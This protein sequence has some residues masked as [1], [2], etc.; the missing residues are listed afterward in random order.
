MTARI[1]MT[2]ALALAL[3]LVTTGAD[4]TDIVR[5]PYVQSV[6]ETSIRV[7]WEQDSASDAEVRFGEVGTA[8]D[9]AVLSERAADRH[10]MLLDGL[11]AD[12]TY[13]Y[14]VRDTEGPLSDEFTFHTAPDTTVA[15][16]FV[17]FGDT[18][19]DHAAH[20]G[21]VDAIYDELDVAFVVNTG[22]LV[23]DGEVANQWD[24][25]FEVEHDLIAS[26]PIYPVIG[27]HEEHDGD[28]GHY[29]NAFVLPRNSPEPEH[30]YS[31]DYSNA[32]FVVLDGH[33]HVDAWYVCAARSLFMD[34][35]FDARQV[36]WLED[37]LTTASVREDIDHIFV[38]THVGPYS[39]K[40]GRSGNA[41][42][43]LLQDIFLNTG[44]TAIISGHDHYYEHGLSGVGIHYIIS[45][46]GGAPLYD[47]SNASWDP[48]EVYENES[49]HHYVVLDVMGPRVD[50]RTQTLDSDGR[51]LEE[52][53]IGPEAECLDDVDCVIPNGACEGATRSCVDYRCVIE[54]PDPPL[55]PAPDLSP[56]ITAPEVVEDTPDA[57]DDFSSTPEV[58]PD[59]TTTED[60]TQVDG[61]TPGTGQSPG[62]VDAP[63]EGCGCSVVSRNKSVGALGF[64]V[65]GLLFR[66]RRS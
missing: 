56:D 43:R 25:F 9:R 60:E 35:C 52:F 26:V 57:G 20:Q 30:Y 65:L 34:D 3:S 33:V 2:V 12:T 40:E 22:D 48:H 16:R 50:I 51:I 41:H 47:L 17:V 62:T 63:D 45:G 18:R 11:T 7:V 46:G 66:R 64:L 38:L 14:V 27:N 44:V 32:H 15:F 53:S 5:G 6:T 61:R 58:T 19:S 31:F 59:T 36:A 21:V 55:D 13:A 10:E 28:V 23:S 29:I 4:A 39:S 1:S 37:D 54:C 42:M 8:L 49:V 24:T